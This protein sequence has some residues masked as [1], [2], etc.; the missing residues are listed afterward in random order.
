MAASEARQFAWETP[1]LEQRRRQ[2]PKVRWS[3]DQFLD[4]LALAATAPMAL[5]PERFPPLAMLIGLAILLVP[6]GVRRANAGRMTAR[7]AALWPL[8]FLLG[9]ALPVGAYVS[10]AFWAVSWPELVRAVWGGGGLPGRD[11]FLRRR[12]KLA[13]AAFGQ[14]AC[15]V[16]DGGLLGRG[17]DPRRAGAAGDGGQR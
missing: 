14:A 17:G 6:Y 3:L 1:P 12:R 16:G 13:F 9:V 7:T 11:Q 4:P 8:L 5:F 2:R 10:P 15:G